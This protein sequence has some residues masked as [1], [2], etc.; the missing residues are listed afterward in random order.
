MRLGTRLLWPLLTVVGAVM[1]AYGAYTAT[2]R[3]RFL[4]NE[5]SREM[6]AYSTAL[7]IAVEYA[8]SVGWS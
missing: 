1:L 4:L 3:E 6:D 7:S 2:R 5:L 8:V